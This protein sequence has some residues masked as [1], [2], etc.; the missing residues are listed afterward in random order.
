M[1]KRL[2]KKPRFKSKSNIFDSLC[3][4]AQ[5][6]VGFWYNS[7]FCDDIVTFFVDFGNVL[8]NLPHLESCL[9]SRV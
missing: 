3:E 7:S 5:F 9:L 1:G 8:I 6:L 2:V 4:D